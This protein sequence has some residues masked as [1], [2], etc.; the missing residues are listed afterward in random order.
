MSSGRLEATTFWKALNINKI[1]KLRIKHKTCH[2]L[3]T[4]LCAVRIIKKNIKMEK[5]FELTL[6]EA[7][8]VINCGWKTEH[9]KELF[10]YATKIVQNESEKHHLKYQLF[11]VNSKLEALK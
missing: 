8:C 5:K 10:E 9:E 11:V 6:I 7:L 1:N 3:Y 2:Y 4:L